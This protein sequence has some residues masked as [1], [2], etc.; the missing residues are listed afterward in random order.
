MWI[1]VLLD[2]MFISQVKLTVSKSSAD[3]I[4]FYQCLQT[5]LHCNFNLL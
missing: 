3:L 4:M 5:I 2:S 1:L